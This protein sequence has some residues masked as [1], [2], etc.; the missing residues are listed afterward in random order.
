MLHSNQNQQN[1]DFCVIGCF[2]QTKKCINLSSQGDMRVE[3]MVVLRI[4]QVFY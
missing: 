3:S 1:Y 4:L 2:F